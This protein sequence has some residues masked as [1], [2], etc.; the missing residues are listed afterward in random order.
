MNKPTTRPD[1]QTDLAR[2]KA[3][4]LA[5]QRLWPELV[6][7]DG[8]CGDFVLPNG[9][10]VEVKA[11]SYNHDKTENFFFEVYSSIESGAAGGP[12]QAAEHEC[13]YFVYYFKSHDIAY[14]FKTQ[15]LLFQIG[16]W[17]LAACPTMVEVP[18]RSW[19]TCGYKAPRS[20]FKPYKVLRGSK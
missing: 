13:T 7:I 3:G 15:D 6:Q 12:F 18:N 1:F 10:K 16:Q 2:G 4:E 17:V 20:E 9:D 19:I 5:V 11:D 8:R 14:V